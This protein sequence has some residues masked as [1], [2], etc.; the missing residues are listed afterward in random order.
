[1]DALEKREGSG[2]NGIVSSAA[3]LEQVAKMEKELKDTK[4]LLSHLLFKFELFIKETG[5][6]FADFDGA[7][8]EI[9]K[10]MESHQFVELNETVAVVEEPLPVPTLSPEINALDLKSLI[11]QEFSATD[12]N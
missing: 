6:K 7:I 4:D 3:S 12:S 1:L 11:K 10:N 8:S 2:N 5:E 9:E